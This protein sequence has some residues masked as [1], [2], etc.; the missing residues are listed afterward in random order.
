MAGGFDLQVFAPQMPDAAGLAEA[1]PECYVR[2]A[3][4]RNAGRP[5]RQP[6][7]RN[8]APAWCGWRRVRT[9]SASYRGSAPSLNRNDP[10]HVAGILTES[11]A[12]FGT[13]RCLY[14]SNFPIEKSV[15]QL[16]RSRRGLSRRRQIKPASPRRHPARHGDA[17]LSSRALAPARKANK[18]NGR[19]NMALEIKILG[20]WRHRA[21][22]EFSRARPRLRAHAACAGRSASHYRRHLSDRHRQPATAPIRSW[23]RSACAGSS[24]MRT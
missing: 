4:C 2:A 15:D 17:G 16:S 24:S 19:Q 9:S 1:C 22:I 12:I 11:V 5:V 20:L 13:D 14:G 7:A 21:G 8:G 3:A 18:R 23:K 10:A 6:A